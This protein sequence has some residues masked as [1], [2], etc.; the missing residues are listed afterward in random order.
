MN[1]TKTALAM[2]TITEG[3]KPAPPLVEVEGVVGRVEVLEL[4]VDFVTTF[5]SWN[6]T[7]GVCL[8]GNLT[9]SPV[10][11]GHVPGNSV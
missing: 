5:G 1:Q 8:N 4:R 10:E 6:F 11:R 3:M 7:A 2:T 9:S